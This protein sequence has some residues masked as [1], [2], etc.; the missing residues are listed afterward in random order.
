MSDTSS[1]KV[2]PKRKRDDL[3]TEQQLS[4]PAPTIP[5][6]AK[7][8]FSFEPPSASP[9]DGSHSPRTKITNKFRA[10]TIGSGGGVATESHPDGSDSH[11]KV[12]E[13]QPK[14]SAEP[15]IF[16]LDGSRDSMA[17]TDYMQ[18]DDADE[19]AVR[20][21]PKNS[22]VGN[23]IVPG[24]NGESSAEAAGPVQ[25]D[26]NGRL[27]LE[28]IID[29]VMVKPTK[30]GGAGGLKKSY[31]SINRLADSKS[32]NR[33]RAGTPP[34]SAPRRKSPE[35]IGEEA[36]VIVDPIRAALTWHEDEITVY[37]SEDKD[38]DGTGL[39]GIGFRPTPA[40]AYQRAQKRKQQLSEYKK[41]EEAEARARRNANRREQLS[42]G[43]ELERK[44]S[45]VRVH[46]SDAEPEAMAM[47]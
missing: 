44:H 39:N 42:R 10:L 8:A 46:F 7:T 47:T 24:A 11:E 22:E 45:M 16:G 25:I 26:E 6:L 37:D 23:G 17:E 12:D 29:P 5:T 40:I 33:K 9:E 28:N 20:K 1:P 21:R 19:T 30:N 3:I 15:V 41:R 27:S 34:Q 31:P 4:G 32:R 38:D 14:I 13:E 18:F 43:S 36:P 35:A 2:T